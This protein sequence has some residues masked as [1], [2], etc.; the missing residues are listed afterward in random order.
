LLRDLL[1]DDGPQIGAAF[2]KT[3]SW[4]IQT[5][6]SPGDQG[7]NCTQCHRLAVSNQARVVEAAANPSNTQLG[8]ALSFAV[9][10]TAS[11]QKDKRPHGPSSPIW[12]RP[13]Q[14]FYN[15]GAEATARRFKNCAQFFVESNFKVAP[16]G[17]TVTPLG[18]RFKTD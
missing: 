9:L 13:D 11:S 8:S 14:V 1:V 12:M 4:S 2:S 6:N 3:R 17:C 18:R 16:S 7:D 15:K 5:S 10:S